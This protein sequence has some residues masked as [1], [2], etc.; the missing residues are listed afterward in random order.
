[1]IYTTGT[2]AGNGS[3]I[4]GTGTN[5][6]AA[7]SL[8]RVGCTLIAF[9]NPVQVLQLTAITNGTTLSVTPAITPAITAGTKYAILLSDSLSVDGLAQDIAETFKMYQAYMGGFADVMNGSGDVTITIN[10]EQATVPG[11]KSLAKKGANSDITSLSG[12]TTPLS[13]PQGGLGANN[14]TEARK[15][16]GLGN[17]ATKTVS[18]SYVTSGGNTDLL[19]PEG[20]GGLCGYN[21]MNGAS[22]GRYNERNGFYAAPGA[23]GTNYFD[24]YAPMLVMTR[25]QS[26]YGMFQIGPTTGR[27]AVR[28]RN[29]DAF[30]AWNELYTTG[31]TTKTAD[32]TLKAASP[33]VKLFA[34]GRAETNDESEGV[35]VTRQ[36]VGEYLIAG[37]M[38]LNADAAWGGIDGGFDIPKDRNR[39]PLIWLDYD[40]NP[41]G[42]IL[43]KTYHR[44]Y[45]DAPVFA[46]NIRDGYENG[47]PIDIPADQFVS[48]RVEMPQNSIWNQKQEAA[49]KAMEEAERVAAEKAKE[50]A[51]RVA[52]EPEHPQPE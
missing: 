46:R 18:A 31:N 41:D 19:L 14:A 44:T 4:T 15:I 29:G 11:Q 37:C 16:L 36:G 43:V 42:S 6:T 24:L 10:G 51:E 47:D 50:E 48:V 28:G 3:T 21:A 13:L 12:L 45:P 34:D 39:Q 27:A 26:S 23:S 22:D 30:T 32:G 49:Q 7:G 5:F 52:A 17:A 33:I 2:I 38:G 1:M 8:I 25:Y 20:A 35:T 40:V 9:T